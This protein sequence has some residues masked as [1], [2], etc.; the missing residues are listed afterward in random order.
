MAVAV[1]GPLL[2]PGSFRPLSYY[3]T[4]MTRSDTNEKLMNKYTYQSFYV[5]QFLFQVHR[6]L[7]QGRIQ[8]FHIFIGEGLQVQEEPPGQ[9]ME[10]IELKR[11]SPVQIHELLILIQSNPADDPE[12]ESSPVQSGHNTVEQ[13]EQNNDVRVSTYQKSSSAS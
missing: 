9:S 1:Y 10:W 3:L 5:N 4:H 7:V 12:S 13:A 2:R 6:H 8:D 11:S